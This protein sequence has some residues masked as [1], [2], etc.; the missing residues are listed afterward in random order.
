MKAQDEEILQRTSLFRF[1]P[2]KHLEDLRPLLKEERYE[3]GDVIVHQGAPADAFYVLISGR[4]RAI[5]TDQNGNEISLATLRPG[6][7]FGEAAL[8]EGGTRNASIRCSTSVAVLR[9][10]RSDFLD[11]CTYN[12]DLREQVEVTKR[13]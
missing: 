7:V 6:D 5:K 12:P 4:A 3:F 8:G 10:A 9:L 13:H 2:E 1:L 11:L